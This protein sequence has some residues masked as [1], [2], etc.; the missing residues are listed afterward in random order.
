LST[1]I[2]G[3]TIVTCDPAGTILE[4]DLFVEDGRI[5]AIGPDARRAAEARGAK[6][7]PGGRPEGRP[8]ARNTGL[9]RVLDARGCAVVPG[10]VQAHV[11]LCQ[12]LFRGMADDLPLLDWLRQRI[13]PLEAAHDAASLAASA[14]L[15]LLEVMRA[16]TTTL[17]DMGT[18]HHY[19]AVFDACARAGI[20]VFGGKTMMDAGDGVPKG[21]RES[22]R[23][24]LRESDRLRE[25]W[26]GKEDGRLGYAYAPRFILSCTEA[27]FRGTVER[28]KS[29][30]ALLHSH[31]AEHPD[32]RVAIKRALGDDD[33]AM[34]RRWGFAGSKTLLAHGVQLRD[35]EVKAIARDGTRIV[36]CPS[37][38]LKLGS[39]IARVA[40]LDARG[41]ALALGADGA[42]CNN[43]LDPWTELRHAALLAK[44]RTGTTALPA[45]RAFRLATIDG[46]R[47]L[48]IEDLVGSLEL[49]KRADVVVVRI[50]GAHVE[51]GGDVM[52]RL[53]Y[54]CTSRDVEHVLVDGSLVVHRG[55]HQRLD[56]EAVVARARVQAKK[57]AARAG[58]A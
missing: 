23:S 33:I 18:V 45:A 8:G 42:P 21:L 16:G 47:A 10:L 39:G 15:G 50:D 29:T 6:A 7:G 46:A 34:L 31:A 11:H 17:L 41:V 56:G 4:G 44:T 32:E 19:D 5:T 48:G 25:T 12:V 2:Q 58:L 36:H 43:N 27:L 26:S 35:D 1:L 54:A 52:S 3:G 22:T 9:V 20:R 57:V 55:E 38:N 24:S 14:E 28:S 13:W 49:G 37:A 30:G 51:P 40:E 53:V